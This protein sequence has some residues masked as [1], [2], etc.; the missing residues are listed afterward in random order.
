MSLKRLVG[1]SIYPHY[2]SRK[3]DPQPNK[4]LATVSSILQNS[5]VPTI[6][7][8]LYQRPQERPTHGSAH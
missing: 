6:I 8:T 4:V 3:S 2:W 7:A 5:W 1:T